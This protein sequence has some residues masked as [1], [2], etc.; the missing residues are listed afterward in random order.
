MN[1]LCLAVATAAALF[2]PLT[3]SAAPEPAAS[4]DRMAQLEAQ[5][6]KLDQPGPT[7]EELRLSR[8]DLKAQQG[9]DRSTGQMAALTLAQVFIGGLTLLGL[10]YTV[11]ATRDSLHQT[12]RALEHTERATRKQ[13]R[14]YVGMAD[15]EATAPW[16]VGSRCPI[17][18]VFRNFG[19]SPAKAVHCKTLHLLIDG[20]PASYEFDE[21]ALDAATGAPTK[22]LPP[23][24]GFSTRTYVTPDPLSFHE[25][26]VRT[27][28]ILVLV[29]LDYEDE[30]G[31]RWRLS[32]SEIRTGPTLSSSHYNPATPEPRLLTAPADAQG[33][34]ALG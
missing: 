16:G 19:D 17:Q 32:Y 13:L 2:L 11:L 15:S 7:P 9:M 21:E 8:D 1:K 18:I 22:S 29:R 5:V 30:F 24:G 10:G 33:P 3:A 6:A 34:D 23:G 14:A 4:P 12:R 27:Q 25:L 26:N 20:N 28:S 31:Y